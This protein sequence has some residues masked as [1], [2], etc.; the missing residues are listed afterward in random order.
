MLLRRPIPIRHRRSSRNLLLDLRVLS[1]TAVILGDI[2]HGEAVR[3]PQD[4]EQPEQVERLQRA[5]QGEGDDEG[6]R[7]LVLP[8]LPV[9]LVG[10]DRL[11]LGEEAEKD[12]QVEEVPQVDPDADE[13][14]EVGGGQPVVEVVEG[15]GGLR[16]GGGLAGVKRGRGSG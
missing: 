8:R 13:G 2:V 16:E 3:N 10:P 12:A 6:Q 4:E 11:E 15:F 14:D 9:E 7:A 5:E 1:I